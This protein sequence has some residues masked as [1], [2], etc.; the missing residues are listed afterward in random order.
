MSAQCPQWPLGEDAMNILI[1]GITGFVGHQT[2]T[3][4]A[5]EGHTIHAMVRS[6]SDKS[7]A[8]SQTTYDNNGAQAVAKA[9]ALHN[10]E[11]V[12]H[13]AGTIN[14]SPE[15]LRSGNSELMRQIVDGLSTRPDIPL[16]F[17]SS[18]SALM[19]GVPYGK[20]KR[21]CEEILEHSPIK[22]W[23]ILRPSLVYGPGDT[24]NVAALVHMVRKL[25]IIPVPGK[26]TAKLQPLH[27]DDL[28]TML[29]TA[30]TLD[31]TRNLITSGPAQL[32][33]WAM[34]EAIE[35]AMNIRRFK[36]PLSLPL[37]RQCVKLMDKALPFLNLPVQQLETMDKQPF[38]DGTEA[39]RL[40]NVQPRD[41]QKGIHA[42]IKQEGKN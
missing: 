42:T 16:V 32:T 21:R 40:F 18:V 39:A 34:L 4:L 3:Q 1:T 24:K 38:W 8:V 15:E 19:E 17:V 12:I 26:H 5:S 11:A 36:I 30:L 14:G 27:V 20:E 13:L 29:N 7:V 28:V 10:I 41:F 6:H 23:T 22:H 2:A 25:P 37:L 9:I 33:L 31:G 35:S